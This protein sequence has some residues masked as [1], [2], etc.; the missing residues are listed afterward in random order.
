MRKNFCV[1][2]L[3]LTALA[4]PVWAHG[5]HADTPSGSVT[6]GP[7]YPNGGPIAAPYPWNS[8]YAPQGQSGYYPSGQGSPA[9]YPSGGGQAFCGCKRIDG[10]L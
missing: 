8:N 1:L 2:V 6:P 3:S 7:V 5:E 4:L 10:R 9:Y